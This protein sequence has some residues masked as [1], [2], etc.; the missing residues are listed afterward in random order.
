MHKRFWLH[1]YNHYC[2]LPGVQLPLEVYNKH[3]YWYPSSGPGWSTPWNLYLC[4]RENY[5]LWGSRLPKC[6]H[7]TMCITLISLQL[8]YKLYVYN[9]ITFV[10]PGTSQFLPRHS[11]LCH[12]LENV[13]P[14]LLCVS[15]KTLSYCVHVCIACKFNLVSD[16]SYSVWC[17]VIILMLYSRPQF[18]LAVHVTEISITITELIF[19]TWGGA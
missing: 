3:I 8:N 15:H 18:W 19:T 16:N 2:V 10:L 6:D 1:C 7:L 14:S 11:P 13:I 17:N 12:M 4:T 9:V 5:S